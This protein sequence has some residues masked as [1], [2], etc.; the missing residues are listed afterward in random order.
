MRAG[1]PRN[2]E[3][4]ARLAQLPPCR[5]TPG[6]AHPPAGRRAQNPRRLNADRPSPGVPAHAARREPMPVSTES[7]FDC[8]QV[9]FAEEG[10]PLRACLWEL[11]GAGEYW[12]SVQICPE[13]A[14]Q[15]R[16]Q[17]A[18]TLLVAVVVVSALTALAAFPFIP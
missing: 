18:L 12:A 7:C 5:D 15:R 16:Y 9:L 4:A 3:P 17:R 13:C 14:A 6:S 10:E 8:G 11:P 2:G 1:P